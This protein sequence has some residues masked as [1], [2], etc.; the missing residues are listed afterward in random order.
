VLAATKLALAEIARRWIAL[1]EEI[2]G[3][4]SVVSR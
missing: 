4:A 1:T 3:L 2:S